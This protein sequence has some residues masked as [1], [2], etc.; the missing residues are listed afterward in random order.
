MS[1]DAF[2]PAVLVVANPLVTDLIEAY[3]GK[4][5][6]PI[7]VVKAASVAQAL[8]VIEAPRPVDL[9]LFDLHLPEANG[10]SGFRSLRERCPHLP[11][12]IL[13]G[14]PSART[15]HAVRKA[16][17]R[18]FLSKR[19][20]GPAFV[21]ALRLLLAGEHYF[22]AA[23]LQESAKAPRRTGEGIADA[24][25]PRELET[26]EH[27]SKGRSNKEIAKAMDIEIVTVTLHLTNIY[28]K[29][30]VSGRLQAVR[31]AAEVGIRRQ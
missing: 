22:P 15:V 30:G 31:R 18:G 10:L 17:A 20:L 14:D 1:A 24:L 11:M 26:L 13:S 9:V 2:V 7:G 27:L 3:L 12:A 19:L 16:G 23:L 29:L 4:T 5:N 25:T 6:P 8:A 21:T 28:R